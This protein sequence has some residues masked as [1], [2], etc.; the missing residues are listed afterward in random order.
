MWFGETKK[1]IFSLSKD[2]VPFYSG[3]GCYPSAIYTYIFISSFL[4]KWENCLTPP[5][6][7]HGICS[8]VPNSFWSLDK[9]FLFHFFPLQGNL[10][11]FCFA[12]LPYR[13]GYGI[14]NTQPGIRPMPPAL[15]AW[16]LTAR[17]PG[18]SLQLYLLIPFLLLSHFL[19]NPLHSF[20][21]YR[22]VSEI[23]VIKVSNTWKT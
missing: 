21:Y 9:L 11:L 7:N 23:L 16:G 3:K 15:E 18:R 12:S 10:T 2:L 5:K 1:N 22:Y 8:L 14:L 4:F 17:P 20:C 19:P 6:A 13:R